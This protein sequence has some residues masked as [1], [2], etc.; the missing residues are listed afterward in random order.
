M[1]Q[2]VISIDPSLSSTAV[3]VKTPT[4][5]KYFSFFSKY[6]PKNKWCKDI[7]NIVEFFN[8]EYSSVDNFSEN[9][10]LKLEQ[11]TDLATTIVYNLA[12]YIKDSIIKIESY[13]Q[14]SRFGKYQDLVTFG[15]IL[16]YKLYKHNK[17]IKFFA[18]K[19]VKKRAAELVYPK[20]KKGIARNTD[21][22]SGGS[23]N[24][25]DMYY[26]LVESNDTSEL[27]LYCRDRKD[28]I[29]ANKNVPKPL[30][31]LIDAY[32]LNVI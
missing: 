23:F 29:T 13:S 22:T 19:E 25:W 11:Y 12:P 32:F 5:N 20:D 9:E 21:G 30:E 26:C 4:H 17:N 24:K 31:D 16:R 1:S 2:T 6:K 7:S 14:E 18:P 27:A 28:M 3:I 10:I 15:T 8:V